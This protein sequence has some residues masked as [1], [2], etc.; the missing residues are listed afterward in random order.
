MIDG[1]LL[2]RYGGAV[3]W[4]RL[5]ASVSSAERTTLLAE[6]RALQKEGT[7][8]PQ[9]PPIF[10]HSLSNASVSI[11]VQTEQLGIVPM[12]KQ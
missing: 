4:Q 5:A 1:R 12:I 11:R 7:G 3:H 2:D 9:E 10:T 6:L 8:P